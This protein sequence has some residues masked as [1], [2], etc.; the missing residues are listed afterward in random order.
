[1]P[2]IKSADQKAVGENIKRELSAGKPKRQAIAIALDVQRRAKKADGGSVPFTVRSSARQL[3]HSGMIHSPI[4]GRTDRIPIGVGRNG[5]VI[6][7]DTVSGLG[8][9][10]SLAG[11]Q[12]L[13]KLFGS[14]P[15]GASVPH[16]HA[17]PMKIPTHGMMN[18]RRGF[19]DGGD[20]GGEPVDI[21]AAG[22]EFVVPPHKVL[23]IGG[24]DYEHGHKVLDHFV[25]HIRKRTIKTLR[26]LPSPKKD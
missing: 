13:N 11:A 9:G 10:N 20:V 3:E 19:A 25:K 4:A 5:Y 15:G 21:V 7:A 22:G 12:A 1:M 14:A 23:E 26:K 18:G 8:Q 2:L 17:Q 16:P 24:G 6:P